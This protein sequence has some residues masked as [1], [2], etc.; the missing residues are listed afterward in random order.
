VRRV[1]SAA[2]AVERL[3]RRELSAEE[4]VRDCL[5]RIEAREG[6]V[7]AWEV[8]DGEAALRE[9]RRIDALRDRPPLCGLPIGVKDLIDTASFPTG[10]GS[11]IYRG[12]RPRADA[13]CVR[14]LRAAGAIVLGK[15][16]TTEFAVYAPGKTRNP[17]DPRR[18]PGGSSS[19]SAAAVADGMVPLALGSQTAASVIRPASFCGVVGWKPTYGVLS[20]EGV[21][22]LAPSLDTLGFFVSDLDDVRV[23]MSALGAPLASAAPDPRP[24]LGLCRTEAWE[25]AEPSTRAA[26]EGAA[27]KL[28]RSGLEVREVTLGPAFAGLIDAQIAIMGAEAAVAL[29]PELEHHA[30]MLSPRLREFLDAGRAVSPERLHAARL[31]AETCRRELDAVFDE[32]DALLTPAA[33]GEAPEG[34]G[35][36]GDP[37]FSRIWTLLGTPCLSLPVLRGRAGLPL[38]LQL[39]GARGEDAAL[40]QSAGI[41]EE[42]LASV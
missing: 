2:R 1:I 38:G 8:L 15:T 20:L 40:L 19:G 6:E 10:Y 24:V 4:L 28:A 37:I 3:A 21:H 27:A 25:R 18:T 14:A 41:I 39:V 34:L 31:Q 33:I 12:H 36:T 17:R 23:A 11:A 32:V 42:R 5:H 22:A 26:V 16:V 35:T 13:A 30:D 9:A 29:R 7:Q